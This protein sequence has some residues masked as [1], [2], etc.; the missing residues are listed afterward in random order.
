MND[1]LEIFKE[2]NIDFY[3]LLKLLLK[4][5]K[6]IVSEINNSELYHAGVSGSASNSR[7]RAD[8]ATGN[9]AYLVVR[10][11]VPC[12]SAVYGAKTLSAWLRRPYTG[13]QTDT[14]VIALTITAP[15]GRSGRCPSTS[16]S[17][18]K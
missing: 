13:N 9:A 12:G 7:F 6:L 17:P 1:H 2:D 5:S 11:T 14:T 8:H 3:V 16:A 4:E 18:S 10:K 15:G